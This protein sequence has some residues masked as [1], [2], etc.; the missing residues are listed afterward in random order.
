MAEHNSLLDSAAAVLGDTLLEPL[1]VTAITALALRRGLL[2]SSGKTPVATMTAR[3]YEDTSRNPS[4]RFLRL[5]EAGLQRAR[6]GPVRWTLRDRP[7]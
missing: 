4:A 5:A 1:T 3:L 7:L 6:R 2:R